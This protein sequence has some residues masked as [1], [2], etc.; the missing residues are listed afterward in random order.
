MRS[1]LNQLLVMAVVLLL[2]SCFASKTLY[3]CHDNMIP[4][5]TDK[6]LFWVN[7]RETSSFPTLMNFDEKLVNRIDTIHS[8]NSLH[9]LNKE[10]FCYLTKNNIADT[11]FF[12]PIYGTDTLSIV[13]MEDFSETKSLFKN[14]KILSK[15]KF[16]KRLERYNSICN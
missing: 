1:L 16:K 7:I 12:G 14:V 2:S 5:I 15:K 13:N 6:Q 3:N 4:S 10:G 8:Y 9:V 11:L